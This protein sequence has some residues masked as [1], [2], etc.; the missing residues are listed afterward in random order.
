MPRGG[1]V[2]LCTVITAPGLSE[3]K[4]YTRKK[5]LGGMLKC[6]FLLVL[7]HPFICISDALVVL[8]VPGTTPRQYPGALGITEDMALKQIP[9][10]ATVADFINTKPESLASWPWSWSCRLSRE[11]QPAGIKGCQ[12]S[13]EADGARQPQVLH[14]DSQGRWG[15]WATL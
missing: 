3:E 5:E 15:R 9:V 7:P 1:E 10:T 12:G 13:V 2:A 14:H 6:Y 4:G 11:P 8:S